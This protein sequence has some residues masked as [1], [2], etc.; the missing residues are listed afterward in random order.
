M[1]LKQNQRVLDHFREFLFRFLQIQII[2]FSKNPCNGATK[3]E[4]EEVEQQKVGVA[5]AQLAA[6][7]RS[8]RDG[9][10]WFALAVAI[11][12]LLIVGVH[13]NSLYQ[14]SNE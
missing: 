3:R 12:A 4:G 8:R 2:L 10:Y 11:A 1:I 9:F 5:P 14:C 13:K 6:G 7:S